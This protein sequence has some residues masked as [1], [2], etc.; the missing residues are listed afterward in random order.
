MIRGLRKFYVGE[1]AYHVKSCAGWY[2][3]FLPDNVLDAHS[4]QRNGN[5][6]PETEG[7][8]DE[9]GDIRDTFLVEAFFP[10]IA[11][12]VDFHNFFIRSFLNLL[13]VRGRKITNTHD[14]IPRDC[15]EA[16]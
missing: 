13:T 3:S 12:G 6:G 15:I 7:F 11:I 14:D 2:S 10:C 1:R 5:D 4:G 8:F 9:G 16:S